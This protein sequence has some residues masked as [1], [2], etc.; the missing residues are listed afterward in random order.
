[1]Q[2]LIVQRAAEHQRVGPIPL[3]GLTQA[4]KA[5]AAPDSNRAHPDPDSAER[6]LPGIGERWV[7]ERPHGVLRPADHERANRAWPDRPEL[8]HHV[9]DQVALDDQRGSDDAGEQ[10]EAG[11]ANREKWLQS[12]PQN[13]NARP[14]V[15]PATRRL[16]SRRRSLA[17]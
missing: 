2:S 12:C 15:A 8:A 11:T 14:R 6:K 7:F 9:V 1:M 4:E 5:A 10:D 3:D 16:E 13:G 17:P